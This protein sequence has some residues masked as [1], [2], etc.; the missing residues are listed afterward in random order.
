MSDALQFIDLKSQYAALKE[1]IAQ[2][3]QAVLDHG[4]Y[5]MGPE[6][7]ELEERLAAFAGAKHCI[8]VASVAWSNR[9][10]YLPQY[11][12]GGASEMA[13]LSSHSTSA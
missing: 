4:Q 9:S 1:R 6:V 3:M 11:C 13:M 5:I 10:A 2:R 12:A 8:T 7:K